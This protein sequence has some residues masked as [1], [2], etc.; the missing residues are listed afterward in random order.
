MVKDRARTVCR[1]KAKLFQ[2]G[3]DIMMTEE[4]V[5][6]SSWVKE[7]QAREDYPSELKLVLHYF[8]EQWLRLAEDIKNIDKKIGAQSKANTCS[9]QEAVY[10]SA[11]G[12]G[13]I[14][15]RELSRELGTLK[16]FSSTKHL[17]SY[18]GLTPSESSSGERRKQGG[19][20]RCGRPRLRH[21]LIEVAWRSVR[22]DSELAEKFAQLSYRRGKKR[23]I[24]AIA[25][26]LIGRI[27]SCFM[28][29]M[30]YQQQ[31]MSKK[32]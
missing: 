16:Q 5:A 26:I 2:F 4:K 25:R 14:S 32:V 20:S 23:A 10:K 22:K 15:S 21:I 13:T 9:V 17:Y 30:Y 7:I 29:G 18:I 24:V 6:T 8:C 27:R 12:I 11:P 1:I 28:N 31:P 19:I 3:Y